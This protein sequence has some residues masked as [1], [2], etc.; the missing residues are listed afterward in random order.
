ME[1]EHRV[2]ITGVGVVCP[3]GSTATEFWE[4]CKNGETVVQRIPESWHAHAD[5]RSSIW[6]PLPT[7][8]YSTYGIGRTEHLQLDP[9]AILTQCAA[10]QAI[11]NSG[12]K[13][14]IRSKRQRSFSISGIDPDRAGVVIGT[15]IGGAKS[16]L[17]NH[18]HHI[19]SRPANAALKYKQEKFEEETFTC[20]LLEFF[21]F[22]LQCHVFLRA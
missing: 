7:I 3:I 12:L 19:L 20:L 6:A 4:N 13:A 2:A 9:V 11:D 16:F 1:H 14:E 10:L 15:G 21:L 18:D 5:L 17:E 8:D 22:V